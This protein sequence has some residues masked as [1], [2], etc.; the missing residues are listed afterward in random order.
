MAQST[1][2]ISLILNLT[3]LEVRNEDIFQI[4]N[5]NIHAFRTHL[6]PNILVPSPPIGLSLKS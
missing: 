1:R 4:T 3:Q 5:E 6:V 2:I